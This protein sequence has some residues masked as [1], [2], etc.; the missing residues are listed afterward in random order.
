MSDNLE[1]FVNNVVCSYSTRC[2]LN[3]RKIAMEGMHVE[4]KK[5]NGMVNMRLRRPYTTANI[6]SSGKITCT[7]A[8]SEEEAY[9]AARRYCRL[10]QRMNFKVKIFNYRV[11]NVLA[12]CIMPFAIDVSKLAGKYQ[13]ECTYEP[14]LH[15]AA[16][17]EIKELKSTLKLFTTGSITLTSPSVDL[18]KQS[19][20]RIY[21][22]LVEFKRALSIDSSQQSDNRSESN[23]KISNSINHLNE[24]TTTLNESNKYQSPNKST[25]LNHHLHT[26]YSEPILHSANFNASLSQT[27]T[28]LSQTTSNLIHQPASLASPL[29]EF[30]YNSTNLMTNSNSFDSLFLPSTATSTSFLLTT[31][32][33]S[34]Q[35]QTPAHWFNDNLLDNNVIDDFLP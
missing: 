1:I 30:L 8:K 34:H 28:S 18:I 27:S 2:H 15:P 10:L 9:I 29:P 7:G 20:A 33:S 19:I 5:E 35:S 6:W 21:P 32:S 4:Y 31:N 23:I 14:E 22:I 12:T 11:V 3:L 26:T 24:I 25:H 13:K 16:T 17:F